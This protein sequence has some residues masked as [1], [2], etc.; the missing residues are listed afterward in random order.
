MDQPGHRS[1]RERAAWTLASSLEAGLRFARFA[2]VGAVSAVCYVALVAVCVEAAGLGPKVASA[3]AYVL[4]LPISYFGHRRLTFR[5]TTRISSEVPKFLAVNAA[6]AAMAIGGMWWA[7]DRA[8][9]DYWVGS[10]LA[11]I[12][13]PTTT[14]ITFQ[15]WVFARR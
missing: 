14:F 12:L 4:A 5:S 1:I 8:G 13:V 15:L 3:V 6:N 10:L 2:G 11:A 7:V 9:H